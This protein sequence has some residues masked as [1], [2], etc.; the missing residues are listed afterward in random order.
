MSSSC[1]VCVSLAAARG[2]ARPATVTRSRAAASRTISVAAAR[3]RLGLVEGFSAKQLRDAYFMAARSA[4]P[5]TTTARTDASE[6]SRAFIAISDAYQMLR[7]GSGA[8]D[9][10]D[11]RKEEAE[12]DFRAACQSWLGCDALLVEE[13]KRCPIFRE[14]LRGNT[15]AAQQWRAFLRLH[16]G[17]APVLAA[18][19]PGLAAGAR[20]AGK[21]RVRRI[22]EL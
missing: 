16:G 2:F 19:P 4:H 17:L 9:P 3:A 21:R 14:W 15:D 12:E 20:P 22:R 6:A 5:D 11:A 7:A 8:E 13:A 18:A 1:G 10:V